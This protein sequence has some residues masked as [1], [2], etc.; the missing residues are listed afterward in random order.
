[1][2]DLNILGY[3]YSLKT[4]ETIEQMD[5]NVGLTNFN[6]KFL[7]VASNLEDDQKKSVLIHE[8]IEALNYHLELNL[9][10]PQIMGLE[11]G[12]HQVFQDNGVDLTPLI[13]SKRKALY[14]R[15]TR[16]LSRAFLLKT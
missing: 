8:L 12:F 15:I 7:Q 6:E 2:K 5:G 1:M 9:E 11:V 16:K 10:H 13:V 3:S 14:D 4:D